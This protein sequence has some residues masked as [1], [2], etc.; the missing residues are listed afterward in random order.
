VIGRRSFTRESGMG[1]DLIRKQPL[2]MFGIHPAWVGREAEYV[3]G[4]K[5]GLMSIDMK[6]GDLGMEA[7]SDE[8]KL[9]VLTGIKTLSL[10]KQGLVT[11]EEF[12]E[13]VKKVTGK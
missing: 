10:D 2:A 12:V 1:V 5:S 13:I 8:D 7:L 4:K 3:L 11:D 9:E 6:L